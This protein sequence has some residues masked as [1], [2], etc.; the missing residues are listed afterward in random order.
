MLTPFLD[1]KIKRTKGRGWQALCHSNGLHSGIK[2]ADQN[3]Y[4]NY[5][6]FAFVRNPYDRVLSMWRSGYG[7]SAP[8]TLDEFCLKIK[9]NQKSLAFGLQKGYIYQDDK[10]LVD[11]VARYENYDQEIEY[12]FDKLSLPTPTIEHRLNTKKKHRQA[13]YTSKS[14]GII[15]ESLESDFNLFGYNKNSWSDINDLYQRT[16]R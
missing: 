10:C 1:K 5:F 12:I 7:G 4:Q 9:C 8:L 16:S 14:A 11:H 2:S 6:K 13:H 3:K 15:F